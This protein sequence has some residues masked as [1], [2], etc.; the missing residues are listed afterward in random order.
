MR[1]SHCILAFWLWLPSTAALGATFIYEG[2]VAGVR[3][4]SATVKLAIADARYQVSGNAAA[5]G[6]VEWFS[7]WRSEFAALGQ[8]EADAPIL[9][10]Y[11]YTQ[12][13]GKSRREVRVRDGRVRYR[14]NQR[15]PR[16]S[17]AFD[18]P[19]LLT[20]L[21]VQPRCKARWW[22]NTG[23]RNYRL[24]RRAADPDVCRYEVFDRH[25]ESFRIDLVLG[26]R[27]GLTIPVAMTVRGLV[28]ARLVLVDALP[29]L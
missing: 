1:A 9:S 6:V 29:A 11:A 13:D 16:N 28:R 26:Q 17:P 2:Y 15:P 5:D 8:L 19:D 4:G 24:E 7:D 14:K 22:V 20:A 3:V 27:N 18:S 21:F 10:E 23:R 25:E 12:H